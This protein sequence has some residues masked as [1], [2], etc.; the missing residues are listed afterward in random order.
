MFGN[1]HKFDCK[2]IV[3]LNVMLWKSVV[4]Q[5]RHHIVK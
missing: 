3:F 1:D 4:T 2:G 5:I